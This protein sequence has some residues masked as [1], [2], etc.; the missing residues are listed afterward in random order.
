MSFEQIQI[1]KTIAVED[2]ENQ[3]MNENALSPGLGDYLIV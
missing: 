1:N 2:G 3:R